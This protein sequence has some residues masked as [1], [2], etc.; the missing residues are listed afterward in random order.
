MLT[1]DS[2]AAN[3]KKKISELARDIRNKYLALK[4]EKS[5]KNEVHNKPFKP[6]VA[7]L[8]KIANVAPLTP[9]MLF[10]TMKPEIK[11]EQPSPSKPQ[12]HFLTEEPIAEFSNTSV[13]SE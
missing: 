4:L 2:V 6:V 13:A 7:P 1:S 3:K 8:N 12:W 5:E 9:L 11:Q 10:T